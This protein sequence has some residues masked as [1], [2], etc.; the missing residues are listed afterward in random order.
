M[1][2]VSDTYEAEDIFQE[3]GFRVIRSE[4]KILDV[5]NIEAWLYRIASNTIIDYYRC[6]DRFTYV[7]DVDAMNIREYDF[8]E[9]DNYNSEA[10]SCLLKLTEFLP[11]PYKEALIESDYNGIKQNILG[12]KWGLSYSGAKN[13]VQRARKKLKET[14]LNCCEV[15]YDK[16]GNI[17]ELVNKNDSEGKFTCINC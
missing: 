8:P 9:M 13:R 17:I 3:V 12:E 1:R 11:D 16:R 15:K 4:N 6:K 7:D 5:K 2:N 14:M 10:G